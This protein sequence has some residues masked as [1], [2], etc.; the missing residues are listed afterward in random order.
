MKIINNIQ[1]KIMGEVKYA[2]HLGVKV[3]ENCSFYQNI[4]WG[5]EPYLISVGDNVRITSNVTF[6]THDGGVHVLRN[7][8]NMKNIDKF[9]RIIIG[10]NVHIGI[11]CIIMPNVKIGNN[12]I[13]GCGS[14]VTKD[15]PDNSVAV[16]VPAKVIETIEEYFEKNKN[17]F[18]N[19]KGM[20]NKQKKEYLIKKYNLDD[21]D[22]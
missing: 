14:I 9:G 22:M 17:N 6:I 3:G 19:T 21:K 2:K 18:D 10:D 11:G 20:T 12:C 16:G 1:K 4:I 8:R 7:Y 15:I 13:I 5:S